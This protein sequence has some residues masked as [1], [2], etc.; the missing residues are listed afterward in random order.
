M[1]RRLKRR[2]FPSRLANA[3]ALMCLSCVVG[4]VT[5]CDGGTTIR[6][7]ILDSNDMPIGNADVMLNV[8]GLTR[9]GKSTGRG[10]FLVG[11]VHAP[12]DP[13]RILTITKPGFKPFEKRFHPKELSMDM[14]IHLER[15]PEPANLQGSTASA[16]S[17]FLVSIVPGRSGITMARDKPDE[18]YV[19]L[20]N[21]SQVPQKAWEYSISWGYQAISFELTTADGKKFAIS[22]RQEGFTRN[23]PSTYVIAAGEHQVFAIRFDKLWVAH[24]SLR[25]ADEIPITLKAIYEVI[26]TPE[27]EKYKVWTGRVESRSYDFTLRQW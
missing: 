12:F 13:E 17:P 26:P 1:K 2:T 24:P 7:V 25:M 4:F 9:E 14:I 10:I 20:T 3:V 11:M 5:G 18:F 6:G 8:G 15:M 21:V 22:K 27:S 23:F 19:L 16:S